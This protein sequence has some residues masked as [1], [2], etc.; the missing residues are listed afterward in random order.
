MRHISLSPY[1]M[2]VMLAALPGCASHSLRTLWDDAVITGAVKTRLVREYAN[3]LTRIDVDTVGRTVFLRGRVPSE[4]VRQRAQVVALTVRP[5]R[6]VVNELRVEE[7]NLA[8]RLK[9]RA[10]PGRRQR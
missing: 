7:E 4:R 3:A 2:A 6:A 5:V 9:D 8:P 1:A 10:R